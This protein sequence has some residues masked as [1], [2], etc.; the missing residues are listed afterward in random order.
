MS[1]I[2]GPRVRRLPVLQRID[3][4]MPPRWRMPALAL[5]GAAGAALVADLTSQ[6]AHALP[7]HAATLVRVAIIVTFIAAGIY[8]RTSRIQ[9]R[10]GMVLVAAGLYSAVWLLN[11]AAEPLPFSVGV[12][13]S[14]FAVPMLAYVILAHPSGRLESRSE[15]RFV[16]LLGGA[17][18]M[19]WGVLVLTAAQPP[20]HTPLVRCGP[21]CPQN[22]FFVGMRSSALGD[23][24]KV[25][26]W[27]CWAALTCGAPLLLVRR[28]Q[29]AAAPVRRAV[30]PVAVAAVANALLWLAFFA[31]QAAGLGVSS[32]FGAAYIETVIAM[33]LAILLGLGLERLFLGRELARFINDLVETTLAD[34]Q[35]L[36]A[37]ALDD[38]SLRIAYP[39][40]G[41]GSYVDASGAPILV[42]VDDPDRTVVWIERDRHQV[43]AVIYDSKLADQARFVQAAGAAALMRLEGVQLE[44]DLMASTRE[45]AASR[46]RL[47][48]AANDERQR[49][50]RDLH[51]G[52]QQ[53]LLGLRLKLEMAGELL[54]EEPRRGGRMIASIGRQM[55][56]LLSSVRS[57]ARGIYPALL[58]E[59]GVQEALKSSARGFPVPISV[60]ARG[61]GRYGREVEIAVY[62]CCL[63]AIQNIAKH[64][65]GGAEGVVRL[66][67]DQQRLCF[68][69]RDSGR[70]FDRTRANPGRGLTNMRDRIEAV[71][72]TMTV[73][74]RE[75]HG[76]SVRG[77]V[78]ASQSAA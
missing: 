4:L 49:I 40:R 56:E 2:A 51:D 47:I 31:T 10:M 1:D 77:S 55:D 23:A 43:A 78:P 50:E 53:Q 28:M 20:F 27:F 62:F 64:A 44:A 33:P 5:L 67:D 75:G 74:S 38:S 46:T 66:W 15:R 32:A 76:T 35:V 58:M 17:G 39:R 14:V 3:P 71:G 59:H 8:A 65:G 61:I 36:M 54:K 57:L 24:L 34:P 45:L 22:V 70:G 42:P 68:E 13:F 63:E 52:V 41:L 29:S 69:V 60:R 48:D 19:F 9:K 73:D 37:N 11:G 25:L 21:Q 12:L 6:N 30:V 72:G 7:A 26:V 18:V 16:A